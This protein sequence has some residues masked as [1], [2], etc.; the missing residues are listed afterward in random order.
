MEFGEGERLE[1]GELGG[2]DDFFLA[3]VFSRES[4]SVEFGDRL[5]LDTLESSK[6]EL[7]EGLLLDNLEVFGVAFVDSGLSPLTERLLGVPNREEGAL[8]AERV[9]LELA[10]REGEEVGLL[11][12]EGSSLTSLFLLGPSSSLLLSSVSTY[13][14]DL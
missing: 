9:G 3:E 11:S 10:A 13:C 12:R 8:P 7:G 1:S 6:V 4:S 5:L 2:L 14:F